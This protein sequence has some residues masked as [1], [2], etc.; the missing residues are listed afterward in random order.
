M[1]YDALAATT[2]LAKSMQGFICISPSTRSRSAMLALSAYASTSLAITEP[3]DWDVWE[4]ELREHWLVDRKARS[5]KVVH[6]GRPG[7]RPESRPTDIQTRLM[8][9]QLFDVALRC[10]AIRL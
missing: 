6:Q 2:G 9:E 7:R 4:C 1:S 3:T 5:P 8:S 10:E